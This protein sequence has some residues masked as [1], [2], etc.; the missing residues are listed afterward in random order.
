MGGMAHLFV[1]GLN[2]HLSTF[3][4][5][6]R[7]NW[8]NPGHSVGFSRA[9]LGQNL[10]GSGRSVGVHFHPLLGPTL[11]IVCLSQGQSAQNKTRSEGALLERAV[12]GRLG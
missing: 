10:P 7:S 11:A 1:S 4:D 5:A 3:R 12:Q 2:S 9:P 8:Y 6:K